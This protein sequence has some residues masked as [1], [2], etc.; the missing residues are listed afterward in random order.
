MAP[1][2]KH[3]ESLLSASAALFQRQGYAATGL[4]EILAESGAPKGSLYHYFPEGKE[5]IAE[6]AIRNAGASTEQR[7]RA[8]TVRAPTLS[9]FVAAY[10]NALSHM[11]AG[12]G[13]SRGCHIATVALE[14]AP[15]SVRLTQA[16]NDVF[17]SWA[18]AIADGLMSAG[19]AAPRA[20]ELAEMMMCTFQGALVLARVQQNTKP[21]ANAAAEITRL[22]ELELRGTTQ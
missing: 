15:Q 17:A 22:F 9:A 8:A 12:S 20:A 10:A 11:M 18:A 2:A 1:A 5:A 13:F 21:I 19:I 4:A 3:R 6:E 7:I 14:A 16:C